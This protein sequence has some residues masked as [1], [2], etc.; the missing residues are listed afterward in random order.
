MPRVPPVC[1]SSSQA[2][3]RDRAPR[4]PGRARLP[5]LAPLRARAGAVRPRALRL[6]WRRHARRHAAV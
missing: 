4:I 5:G 2:R 1:W 6:G 3:W